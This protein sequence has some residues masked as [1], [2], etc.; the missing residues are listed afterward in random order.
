M[1]RAS[2]CDQRPSS[3]LP[4]PLLSRMTVSSNISV[5]R[6]IRPLRPMCVAGAHSAA[7]PAAPSLSIMAASA[8]TCEA[9]MRTQARAYV[10]IG[11]YRPRKT[12]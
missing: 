8:K 12:F 9:D 10:R 6:A 2:F 7:K 5:F 11:D 4:L 3:R 1:L